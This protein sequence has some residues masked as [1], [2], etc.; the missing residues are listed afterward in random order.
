MK[1]NRKDRVL[2]SIYASSIGV[3]LISLS[4]AAIMEISMFAYNS[5]P[6]IESRLDNKLKPRKKR[7]VSEL[8]KAVSNHAKQ[9]M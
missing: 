4:V 9:Q 5:M 2:M 8:N 6:M 3:S 1:S 7:P